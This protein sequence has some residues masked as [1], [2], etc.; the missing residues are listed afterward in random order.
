MSSSAYL[1]TK[2]EPLDALRYCSCCGIEL[3]GP[4]WARLE[5]ARTEDFPDG[6]AWG[7]EWR[8]CN[9]GSTLILA[10]NK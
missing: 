9:C 3:S 5:V 1:P 7:F 6:L 8:T 2:I 4:V 10:I